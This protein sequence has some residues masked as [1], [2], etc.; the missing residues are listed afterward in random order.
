MSVFEHEWE[1]GLAPDEVNYVPGVTAPDLTRQLCNVWKADRVLA[2]VTLSRAGRRVRGAAGGAARGAPGAGQ[3]DLEAAVGQGVAVPPG[4]G[5][6]GSPRSAEHDDVLDGAGRHGGRYR[7]DLLRARFQSVAARAAWAG[8]S[9]RRTTGSAMCASSL[10]PGAELELVPIEVPAGGAAFHDGWTFHGSPPNERPDAQRRSIISH[11]ISTRHTVEPGAS[12]PDLLSLP[13]ARRDRA[14]R[15][16]LPGS[17]ARRIPDPVAVGIRNRGSPGLIAPSDAGAVRSPSPRPS[18]IWLAS[19]AMPS[20]GLRRGLVAVAGLLLAIGVAVVV[21][22]LVNSGS[23]PPSPR[24]RRA[25]C[26][27]SAAPPPP[28]EPAAEAQAAP[29]AATDDPW[30]F[31]GYDLARTRFFPER[32]EARPAAQVG[33][34]FH[35]GALLEFPPV[36][37][38]NTLYFED[39][40]GWA[41]A[42]SSTNGH[43]I[44]HRRIGTVA[45]ASPALDIRHKLVFFTLLSRTPGTRATGN[46]AVVALSMKTGKVAWSHCAAVRQRVLAA[47]ARPQRVPGRSGRHRVLVQDL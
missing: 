27:A 20:P 7:D 3:R 40:N 32:R 31:Y 36:I 43:L 39:A 15:G 30:P 29:A 10:P 23:T 35:D 25:C 18:R 19:A 44:W 5:V 37:Y 11:M 16:V 12:A 4:R 33:W 8:R 46:G 13:A 26:G 17:V 1:T 41:S 2:G 45:A 38:D 22:V 6:S 28:T 21:L 9:T 24:S 42:L 14:R 34:S 47:G